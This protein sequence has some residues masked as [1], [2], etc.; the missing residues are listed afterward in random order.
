MLGFEITSRINKPPAIAI[1]GYIGIRNQPKGMVSV[2]RA[3]I[4]M[5]RI[6]AVTGTVRSRLPIE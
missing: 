1:N 4:V 6:D 2:D 5:R 3:L